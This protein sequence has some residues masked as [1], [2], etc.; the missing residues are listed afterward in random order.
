MRRAL[1]THARPKALRVRLDRSRRAQAAVATERW[2][3]WHRAEAGRR[4]VSVEELK[5]ELRASSACKRRRRPAA[6]R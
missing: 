5:A 4:G 2:A 3:K 6:Q 1:R